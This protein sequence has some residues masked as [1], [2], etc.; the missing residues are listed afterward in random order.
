VR[1]PHQDSVIFDTDLD[2]TS[3]GSST[4]ITFAIYN[5]GSIP[6]VFFCGPVNDYFGRRV[7]MFTGAIIVVIGTCIQ[8][9]SINRAMFLIGRFIL[10]FGVSF[11]CVSAPCYVSEVCVTWALVDQVKLICSQMA[12][13]AWRGTLTGLY[14]CTWCKSKLVQTRVYVC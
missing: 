12:H 9:P 6:A 11:C 8:A 10:G 2:R 3:A 5:I 13:P 1:P 14:N 7:G 4:G